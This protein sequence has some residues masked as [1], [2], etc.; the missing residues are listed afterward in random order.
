MFESIQRLFRKKP[1]PKTAWVEKLWSFDH[2]GKTLWNID[3]GFRDGVSPA[4][5]TI[6]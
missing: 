1:E 3:F 5:S 4:G 2:E 6:A